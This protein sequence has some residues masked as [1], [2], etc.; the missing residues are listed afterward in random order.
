[1]FC[2]VTNSRVLF[3]YS[4]FFIH[5]IEYR[6]DAKFDGEFVNTGIAMALPKGVYGRIAPRSGLAVKHAI[7]IDAGVI[8]RD[9][10]GEVKVV[11]RNNANVPLNFIKTYL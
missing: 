1:M 11:L 8:D 3:L 5:N 4:R 7:S 2:E 9:Y 6:N 10:R